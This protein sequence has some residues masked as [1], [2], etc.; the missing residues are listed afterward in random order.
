MSAEIAHTA[1]NAALDYLRTGGW[2][3]A[4]LTA[5][6]LVM[7][8]AILFKAR[9]LYLLRRRGE[10]GRGWRRELETDFAARRTGDPVLDHKI[11]H[12]LEHQYSDRADTWL[13]TILVLAGAAPLL[14]LLGTVT[15]MVLTFRE[16]A[17]YGTGNVRAL[18]AGISA[19]LVTTQAGL[20]VAIPGFFAGRF[21]Q[22][23]AERHKARLR[24]QCILL[25]RRGR[26]ACGACAPPDALRED[27]A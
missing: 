5:L 22:R 19:A 25:G 24:R 17:A 13:G 9:Q 6:S 26:P 11:L 3:M 12:G 2:V 7:W 27:A 21:L 1:L 16:I 20:A 8:T 23:R 10:T 18:S 15:G 14:G 4:P